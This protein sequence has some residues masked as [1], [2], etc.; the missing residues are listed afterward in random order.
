MNFSKSDKSKI[1]NALIYT[2]N[3]C[4]K[5]NKTK[6]LKLLYLMEETMARVYH[7]PFLSLPYEVWQFGAVQKDLFAELSDGCN[8]LLKDYVASVGDTFMAKQE[9]NDDEFS[10]AEIEMMDS[11]LNKYGK[12]SASQ[13]VRFLHQKDGLWYKTAKQN[14]LLSMFHN[15]QAST[16]KVEIDMT[17]GLDDCQKEEYLQCKAIRDTASQMRRQA[18]V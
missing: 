5:P 17:D 10:D 11:V 16:S 9:F 7:T 12:M 14:N 3:H 13:L 6:L 15:G 1:G 2:I 4:E 18:N 8:G